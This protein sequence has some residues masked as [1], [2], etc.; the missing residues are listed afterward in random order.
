MLTQRGSININMDTSYVLQKPIGNK[1]IIRSNKPP[2]DANKKTVLP[3]I[4]S[5]RMQDSVDQFSEQFNKFRDM[6]S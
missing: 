3:E 2:K 4:S 5:E 1:A 6:Y